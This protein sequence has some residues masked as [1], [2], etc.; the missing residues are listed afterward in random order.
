MVCL[1]S[2]LS[3]PIPDR[4]HRRSND[5]EWK[6]LSGMRIVRVANFVSVESGGLRTTLHG[7]G[8]GYV[9]AGHEAFLI[10]PGDEYGD[11]LTDQGRVITLPGMP[12]AGNRRMLVRRAPVIR[13]L[14]ELD[15]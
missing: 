1:P 4:V 5:Q 12:A 13:I 9:T 11:V 14:E 6:G 10:V 8:R 2:I 15:P 3:T 7:L